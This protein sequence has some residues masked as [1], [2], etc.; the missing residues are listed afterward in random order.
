M[1]LQI[2]KIFFFFSLVSLPLQKVFF[3]LFWTHKIDWNSFSVEESVSSEVRLTVLVLSGLSPVSFTEEKI[4]WL[5]NQKA[6][7]ILQLSD[8]TV[9]V[10]LEIWAI[11]LKVFYLWKTVKLI[12][13]NRT[14]KLISLEFVYN[15]LSHFCCLKQKIALHGTR[16]RGGKR[17]KW[18]NF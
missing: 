4:I 18:L 15:R 16:K 8:T 12:V 6:E 5:R 9:N 17:E 1:C 13:S 3:H 11:L 10:Y 2:K 7:T 14:K